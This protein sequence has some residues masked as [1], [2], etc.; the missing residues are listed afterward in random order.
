MRNSSG[1]H[2]STLIFCILIAGGLLAVAGCGDDPVEP[3]PKT[4]GV[5]LAELMPAFSASYGEM[6]IY[7]FTKLLHEDFQMI[8]LPETLDDWGWANDFYFNNSGMVTIHTNLFGGE[9]G[10]SAVGKPFPPVE[11]IVVELFEPQGV[12]APIP[13]EDS[14]FGESGGQWASYMVQIVFWYGEQ[15]YQ[16]RVQQVVNFYAV[17]VTEGGSLYQ[18]L[19][20]RGLSPVRKSEEASW[21]GVLALYR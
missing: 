21:D 9:P 18:L 3:R 15:S 19:G 2:F 8:L 14:Y 1:G 12:W 6:Q 16:L 20:I 10:V 4:V 5:P 7:Q 17:P 13:A 11:S